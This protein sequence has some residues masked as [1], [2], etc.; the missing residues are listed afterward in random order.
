MTESLG[1]RDLVSGE[2]PHGQ[3]T[4]ASATHLARSMLPRNR[5]RQPTSRGQVGVKRGSNSA[6]AAERRDVRHRL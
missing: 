2:L 6:L 4:T 5:T 1:W 3:V